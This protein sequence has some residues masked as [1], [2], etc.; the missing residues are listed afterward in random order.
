MTIL[1]I[2]IDILNIK[3]IK[4]FSNKKIINFYKKILTENEIIE[5][6]KKKNKIIY[7]SKKFSSKE[8]ASKALGTGMKYGISFKNFEI[9]HNKNGKPKIK[10]LNKALHIIKKLKVKKIH[11]S[12]TDEKKY[13]QSIVIIE[14]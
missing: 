9:Y 4:K 3:R 7:L 5:Y 14:K 12:I 11:I 13:V 1:G 10:F 6:K 2:G 8:A